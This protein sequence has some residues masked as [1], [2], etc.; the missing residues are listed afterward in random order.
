LNFSFHAA[1]GPM[2]PDYHMADLETHLPPPRPHAGT[3]SMCAL[4]RENPFKRNEPSQAIR[5]MAEKAH[6]GFS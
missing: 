5:G 3:A 4:G 2:W 1:A 6:R